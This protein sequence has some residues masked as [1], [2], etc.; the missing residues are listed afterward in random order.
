MAEG[1]TDHLLGDVAEVVGGGTPSTAEP[2]YWGGSIPWVTPGEVTRNEGQVLTDTERTIT[3]EGLAAS[4]AT[5]L[6]KHAVLMTS[7]ATVGA[8]AL[9]GRPMATNQGFAALVA[10]EGVLP[11]FLMYWVQVNRAEFQGRASGSTFPEINRSKVKAIPIRLPGLL[12]QRRIVDLI[13]ALDAHIEALVTESASLEHLRSATL[14]SLQTVAESGA[15]STLGDLV[16]GVPGA[17]KTG[18]FGTALKASE[19]TEDGVPVISTSEVRK[20]H[21]QVHAKTPKVGEHV[22]RRL[23][24]YVLEHGDIVFARKGA[25]DRSAWVKPTERGYFLGS[26]GLRVRTGLGPEE[27]KFIALLLQT[28]HVLDWLDAH[29]TGTI[30]KGL[31]Q[32]ILAAIPLGLPEPNIRHGFVTR[33]AAMDQFR[34]SLRS[35][36]LA[37]APSL[38]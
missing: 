15:Q 28:R 20:G 6:P 2:S 24:G 34:E 32:R 36:V 7:R 19:Y 4:S 11:Y 17:I 30:M 25:V 9:A 21:L 26:D 1:W 3:P 10:R 33:M 18:P 8:V 37:L 5:R 38:Q 35:E 23:S 29:A 14:M 22:L 12:M 16:E 31:N 13:G 27:S